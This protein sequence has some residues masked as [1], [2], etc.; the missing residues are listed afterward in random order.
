MITRRQFSL[1]TGGALISSALG[2]CRSNPAGRDGN[3]G[4]FT[5]RPRS[6]VV[7]SLNGE[8]PLGLGTPR[9]AI[10]KLPA[11]LSSAPLPLVVMLHGAGQSAEW[12]LGRVASAADEAGVA[13][14]APYSRDHSW[15]AVHGSFG[16]D[17]T[18]INRALE[19][20]FD[21][22]VVDPLRTAIGGFSDGA[23]YAVSLGLINGDIFNR[24]IAF[25]PGFI[26][27]GST[28]GNPEFFITHGTEDP[29]LPIDRCGRRIAKGLTQRGYSVTFREF[30]GKH[31]VPAN[32][33]QEAMEWLVGRPAAAHSVL[34]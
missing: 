25:S 27:D 15:D 6:N 32:I 13:V 7:T 3:D 24:V 11:K 17:V 4:R 8:Q 31:E 29:I 10:I 16:P 5:A 34:S 18:F 23:T 20:V 19:R 9:D 2:S 12:M 33:A 1:L 26:I 30:E 28:N 22:V 14:L 21:S